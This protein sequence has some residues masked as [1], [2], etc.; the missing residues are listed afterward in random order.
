[1]GVVSPLP[2]P[3]ISSNI[4]HNAR[5]LAHRRLP[6]N[7]LRC[8]R[9][10]KTSWPVFLFLLALIVPWVIYVGPLRMSLYRIVLLVMV[11]P[12]LAMWISGKAGRIRI[13]DVAVALFWFWGVLSF[14][15]INGLS[16]STQPSGIG[17]VE[18]LGS[19]M[20]ARCFIRDAEDF[21]NVVHLLFRIVLFL[22][23]FAVVELL[24]GFNVL[25]EL[26]EIIFPTM[27]T[28]GS[29]E[30]RSGLVRVRTVFD[31]PILFGVCTGSLLALV[32]LVLGYQVSF[33]PVLLG[34]ELS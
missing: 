27:S 5:S 23:P 11:V 21:H 8:V 14:I 13:A 25:S 29:S 3:N 32:H 28:L 30:V 9:R 7:E 6:N 20:L 33:F 2:L 16:A 4:R 1:M 22:F 12:C 17:F 31:H 34:P 18:T 15:E 10:K 26:S 19:Y 24:T